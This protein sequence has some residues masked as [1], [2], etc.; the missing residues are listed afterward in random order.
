MLSTT[1]RDAFSVLTAALNDRNS[2]PNLRA[3]VIAQWR[4]ASADV[5]PVALEPALRD[6]CA[7]LDRGLPSLTRS[8][9]GTATLAT[10][11]ETADGESL[12]LWVLG[13]AARRDAR[14]APLLLAASQLPKWKSRVPDAADARVLE[15]PLMDS[16]ACAPLTGPA[17]ILAGADYEAVRSRLEILVWEAG[18]SALT[19]PEIGPWIFAS[20]EDF[21]TLVGAWAR[22][23]LRGR[24]LAARCLELCAPALKSSSPPD[25]VGAA[26]RLLQ[27]LMLHPEPLVWVHAARALGR[28]AGEFEALEGT[29]LDWM[30]AE[31]P[32]LRQRAITAF[33]SLP[34]KKLELFGRE[35]T[36]ILDHPEPEPWALAAIAAASPYLMSERR[37]YW[38]KLARR[39]LEGVGGAVSARALARGVQAI[40]RR[41]GSQQL[42]VEPT[43]RALRENAR[44]ARSEHIADWRRWLTVLAATDPLDGAERDPLDLEQG[45]ENLVRLAAQYDDEEADARAARFAEALGATFVE[46]QRMTVDEV[47]PRRRAAGINALEGIA[48]SLAL[49]LWGPLLATAPSG[50]PIAEPQLDEAWRI[51][52]DSS[53]SL[54]SLVAER[55]KSEQTD[56]EA[57]G[58]DALEVLAVQLGGYALD[59]L[60]EEPKLGVGRGPAAHHTCIWLREIQGLEDGSRELPGPLKQALS[61]LLWRL[62]DV[63]RGTSLG[64]VDDVA[65]LGPFAAWWALVIDRPSMIAQLASALPM[66]SAA[67]LSKCSDL[68]ETLRGELTDDP[69]VVAEGRWTNTVEQALIDLEADDTELAHSLLAFAHAL[70]R[71]CTASGPRADLEPMC[72]Q[73][74]IGAERLQHSLANPVLALHP[75]PEGGA[76]LSENAPRVASLVAR[77]IRARDL[78]LVG[79]WFG[80]LGPV[81]SSI[82]EAAVMHAVRRTPPPPPV[83]RKPD[84][85]RTIEGYELVAPLGEGGVGSV[86]LVRKPGADRLFVLKIPKVEALRDANEAERAGILES[87]VEE[88]KALA[89]LYHPNV[90]NIIDRGVSHESP[91]LVLEYLIGADLK[92]YAGA[93]LLSLFE[94]RTIVP[95]ACAG[96]AA[97]HRAGLVHRDIKPANLWLRLPLR[98]GETF[99]PDKHRD[100]AKTPVL[101]TTVI[102]FGMVRPMKVSQEAMGRFVAGTPGYIAP[103]QV[104]DPMELDGRADVY[105]VAGTIYNVTTGRTF[106]DDISDARERIIAHMQR[107]P[108]ED[109]ERLRAFP[110]AIAKL[111][112]EGTAR[113]PHDR[114]QPLEFG[115]AFVEAL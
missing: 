20:A 49:G 69:G 77:A 7:V 51:V 53:Q 114:P 76:F 94:L 44:S 17:R 65:W 46:A 68:A 32:L 54:L 15:G 85:P 41:G 40:W 66:L 60:G 31:S 12:Y 110:S 10:L 96:L 105:A 67:A 14:L 101:A 16:L 95:E 107:D 25:V 104:L 23:P 103:E 92:M 97:L 52:A 6:A 75:A 58:C 22:G 106:F 47:R 11:F 55:R 81:V 112:R 84:G 33:S 28:F 115:R 56:A 29:L 93:R 35:L 79:V 30:R 62:V 26:L 70:Q 45:L 91:F 63:T 88:A 43:L 39:V 5:V 37:D 13:A 50:A 42:I 99:E 57:E 48:R 73:L 21:D 61:A 38:D 3:N 24:V 109:A 59:A 98:G 102:D 34:K 78:E 19:V 108:F 80:S 86:W 36:E 2:P 87:F 89:G 9:S 83:A 1:L 18:A 111:L 8:T 72:L 4:G 113:N 27:P 74:A 71:F 100:P 82:V 90:A 64:A